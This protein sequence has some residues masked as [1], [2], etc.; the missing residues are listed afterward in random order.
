MLFEKATREDLKFN[1]GKGVL[2]IQD[3]W[4]LSLENLNILAKRLK[5]ELKADAEEDYLAEVST[6]DAI[7]KLKF[8]VVIYILNT[9]KAERDNRAGARAIK[10][11]EQKLLRLLEEAENA[12]LK[13]LTPAELRAKIAELHAKK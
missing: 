4:K 13:E 6:V 2:I 11:E 8:D 7:T 9:K 1:T 3:L 5:L 12:E 10:A